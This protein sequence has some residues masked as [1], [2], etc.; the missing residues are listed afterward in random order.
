M[1]ETNKGD[2][3][4]PFELF[5]V[6]CG[7]GWYDLLTPIVE[8]VENYN[9]DKK[10]DKKI[11]FTQIKEKWGGLRVYVNFGTK[12]L[13]DL[14]DKAEEESYNVCEFCGTRE[15]MGSTLS[16]WISSICLDCVKNNVAKSGF[17][18]RWGRNSDKKRFWIN[19]DGTIE[20]IKSQLLSV[21]KDE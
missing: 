6:E 19:T 20:E 7:K 12:E 14:I 13:F 5:G 1:E 15:N 8:Y 16:G 21:K 4:H 9:K 18:T 11:R 2:I 10:D 3:P 17:P